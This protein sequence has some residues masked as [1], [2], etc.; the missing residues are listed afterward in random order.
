MKQLKIILSYKVLIGILSVF[1]LYNIYATITTRN[2]IGILPILI[3][4][5]LIY[6]L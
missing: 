5:V 2:L 6:L 1:I 3:Q 4:S